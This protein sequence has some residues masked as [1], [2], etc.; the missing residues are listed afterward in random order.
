MG[1]EDDTEAALISLDQPK[2]FDRVDHQFLATVLETP[3]FQLQMD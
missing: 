2:A 3:G 1:I